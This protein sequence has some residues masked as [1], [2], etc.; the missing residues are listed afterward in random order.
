MTAHSITVFIHGALGTLALA[1]FWLAGAAKK[2][3]PVHRASGKV[4][5]LA[6]AGLLV[7][8]IPLTLRVLAGPQWAFGVFLSFLLILVSTTIWV[9]W[10]AIRDKRDFAAYTGRVYRVL[11]W[12]NVI[13]GAGMLVFGAMRGQPVFIAFAFVG[14]LSGRGMLR[15]AKKGPQH[16]RWWMEEHLNAMIGNGV[17]THIAFLLIG[18]PRLIPALKGP[19]LFYIAWL[20]P[21]LVAVLARWWLGRRYLPAAKPAPR[22]VIPAEAGIQ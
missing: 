19:A 18:L 3:S 1:T 15:V 4:Y 13:G 6:M 20:A 8:A 12:L 7:P 14:L 10:R 9:S 21:L 2:G 17:A 16:P 5:L 22:A 11:A